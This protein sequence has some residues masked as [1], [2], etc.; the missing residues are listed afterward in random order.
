ML[1]F[2]DQLLDQIPKLVSQGAKHVLLS[3]CRAGESVISPGEILVLKGRQTIARGE[4][5][6]PLERI[7]KCK[8]PEKATDAFSFAPS[9]LLTISIVTR[10][11][12]RSCL[13]TRQWSGLSAPIIFVAS[14]LGL[15][16]ISAN[17]S[18]PQ[19]TCTSTWT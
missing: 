13:K 11:S 2:W 9:G 12:L 18:L 6:E 10:D 17:L 14:F 15:R 7:G 5:S 8:S 19:R 4:R 3:R 1:R 16:P